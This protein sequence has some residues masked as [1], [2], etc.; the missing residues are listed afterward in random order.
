MRRIAIIMQLFDEDR[1][2]DL[3]VEEINAMANKMKA[4][5]QNQDGVV[6]PA[7][8]MQSVGQNRPGNRR[9]GVAG[10]AAPGAGPGNNRL[11]NADP[12]ELMGRILARADKDKDGLISKEEAPPRL[13][14]NF[15]RLDTDGDGKLSV[16][17]MTSML[18]RMRGNG[19]RRDG[20]QN[21]QGVEP[22]RPGKGGGDGTD[23]IQS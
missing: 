5:D 3:S 10:D 17:E 22:K 16:D 13:Q 2:G 7:E 6:T 12:K 1:S 19:R 20:D 9:P 4:M 11:G 18:D 23:S 15:D 14:E 8:V 21:L